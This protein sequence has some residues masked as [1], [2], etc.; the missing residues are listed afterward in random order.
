[1]LRK[2]TF[3]LLLFLLNGLFKNATNGS[4]LGNI[5]SKPKMQLNHSL[6]DNLLQK[7]VDKSGNVNYK[8]FKKDHASLIQF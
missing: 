4:V 3:V 5:S 7:H 6:W 8:S 1:M 2:S